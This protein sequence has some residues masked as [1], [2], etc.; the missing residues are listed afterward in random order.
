M[1]FL[2]GL[3]QVAR[4]AGLVVRETKYW[5]TRTAHRGGIREVRGV[6]WHHTATNAAAV[7]AR[8]N[9][10]LNY[11]IRG[12]G[13]P[14]CNLLLA[15]DGSLDVIAAGT[16]AHA[17][18]GQY[19]PRIPRDRGNQFL[20]GIE[21]EGTTGLRWSDAQLET[22]A[23]LGAQLDKE[24]G[25]IIHIGHNEYAP[26][27]KTDPTG[28]PGGMPALRKAINR[29]YWEKSGKQTTNKNTIQ[30]KDWFDMA[31][32]S[33][34]R[35]IIREETR[36]AKW[37]YKGRNET[38]DAYAYQRETYRLLEELYDKLG[39]KVW[40]YK[41]HLTDTDI[42]AYVRAT[43]RAALANQGELEGILQ[44][45]E[46]ISRGKQVDLAEVRRAAREGVAKALKELEADVTLTVT[47]GDDK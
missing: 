6:L 43:H 25:R 8:N 13:Y 4:D 29:G 11:V 3:A 34:L 18:K 9:P 2:T 19:P 39:R 41:N 20:I 17:G 40:G 45:L 32:K 5:K 15:W 46:Q 31:T 27:R 47:A 12:L 35:Q 26:G 14:L 44:A 38:W 16:G 33:E 30:G 10:T 21:V 7:K 23:R 37:S 1:V 28:I 42:Y 22:A 24:F 36:L